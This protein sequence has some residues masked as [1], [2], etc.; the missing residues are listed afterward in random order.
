MGAFQCNFDVIQ[1]LGLDAFKRNEKDLTLE[2]QVTLTDYETKVL[3]TL[4]SVFGYTVIE[5]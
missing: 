3:R 2:T 1:L 5:E 4:G